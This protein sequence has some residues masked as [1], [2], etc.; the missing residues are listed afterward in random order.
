MGRTKLASFKQAE[1]VAD[2]RW[3]LDL[4]RYRYPVL[5]IEGAGFGELGE[6]RCMSSFKDEMTCSGLL[7]QQR[8]TLQN[9]IWDDKQQSLHH[10]A[11][12]PKPPKP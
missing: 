11:K 7:T 5:L 4:V 1:R 10:R 12:H 8:L 2:W 9:F 6:V 3:L